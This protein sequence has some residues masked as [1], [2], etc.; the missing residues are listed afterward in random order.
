M[1]EARRH[2]FW[3]NQEIA[4]SLCAAS[5]NRASS[6]RVAT[7]GSH[8]VVV[9]K[10]VLLQRSSGSACSSRDLLLATVFFQYRHEYRDADRYANFSVIAT[11]SVRHSAIVVACWKPISPFADDGRFLS[12]K[13]ASTNAELR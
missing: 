11:F 13:E 4:W 5:R 6:S 1:P 9:N 2:L 12:R 3:H 8:A 10:R 7:P